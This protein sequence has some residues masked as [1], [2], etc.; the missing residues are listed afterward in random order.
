MASLTEVWREHR[1]RYLIVGSYIIATAILL[2]WHQRPPFSLS[3]LN[4]KIWGYRD[5]YAPFEFQVLKGHSEGTTQDSLWQSVR[6][7]FRRDTS[8]HSQIRSVVDSI[9]RSFSPTI[10]QALRQVYEYA[11]RYGY[12]DIPLPSDATGIAILHYNDQV[13]EEV[14]VEALTDSL[15]LR[16]WLEKTFPTQPNLWPLVRQC[17][18]PDCTY[19]PALAQFR[20]QTYADHY[21]SYTNT[22]QKGQ[23]II[24]QGEIITPEKAQELQSLAAAYREYHAFHSQVVSFIGLCLLVSLITFLAL[25]YLHV[26]QRLPQGDHRGLALIL[27]IYLFVTTLAVGILSLEPILTLQ[28][29]PLYH[30]IPLAIGPMLLAIFFDDRVGFISAITISAQVSLLVPEPVEFFFVHGLSSML[31]VFRLRAVQRRSD[32]FHALL[33]LSVGYTGSYIGYHLYKTGHFSLAWQGLVPLY[34]NAAIGLAT[35]PLVYGFERLFRMSSDIS[36]LELL[37]TNHPLLRELAQRA[38]GTYQHSLAVA[39]LAEAAAEQI[40]AHPLKV[41]VMALFH[42]IGKVKQ[43][44]YFIENLAS[45]TQG[46]A[47]NPHFDLSPKES[48]QII[49]THV[50]EGVRLAKLYRLPQEVIGGIQTHHGTTLIAYFWDKYKKQYPHDKDCTAFQYDGP[51][52]RTKEEAIL[53][54]A[55]TLE[56]S[57]R[58]IHDLTPEVLAAHVRKII[59]QR[60]QEGQL[61]QAPITLAQLKVLEETFC[62]QLLSQYHS[63]IQYPAPSPEPTPAA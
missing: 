35:Y 43:P 27:S 42:D 37:N 25:W 36:F 4:E 57:T 33:L 9:A 45:I 29:I 39:V 11:Y 34:I 32:I 59:N 28:N 56:A 23:L 20:L 30:L 55:D 3:A 17:F 21:P 40:G 15:R 5:L 6:F 49:K 58:A 41:H 46:S 52:P 22:I 31:T 44:S 54:L 19:D 61:A 2:S 10:L 60:L 53:L 47:G 7:L 50:H 13:E 38:P 48:A 16:R 63:R 8:L 51:M 18:K 62:R 14:P 12:T 26:S 1:L 24:R